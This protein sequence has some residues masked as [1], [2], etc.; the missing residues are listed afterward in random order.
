MAA[1]NLTQA[2]SLSIYISMRLPV[3]SISLSVRVRR[4]EPDESA[5]VITFVAQE[6]VETAPERFEG[7]IS[8]N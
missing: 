7:N 6:I 3:S 1:L 8:E 2:L 4:I 5:C